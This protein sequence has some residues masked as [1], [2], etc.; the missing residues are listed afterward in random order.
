MTDAKRRYILIT[1]NDI[2]PL[3]CPPDHLADMLPEFIGDGLGDP[4]KAV[5]LT[6][7]WLTDAEYEALGDWSP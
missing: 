4:M 2:P 1:G 5:T 7:T 3:T 6:E